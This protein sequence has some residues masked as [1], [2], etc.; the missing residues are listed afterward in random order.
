MA[1]AT[2]GG[3][4]GERAIKG[5]LVS[6]LKPPILLNAVLKSDPLLLQMY[7]YHPWVSASPTILEYSV[8]R[9]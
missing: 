1:L 9:L 3:A 5:A 6:A 7:H 8:P 2:G 4:E